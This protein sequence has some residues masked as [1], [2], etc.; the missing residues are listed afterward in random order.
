MITKKIKCV[1]EIKL[2]YLQKN[3]GQMDCMIKKEMVECTEIH[4][5][6]CIFCTDNYK[7]MIEGEEL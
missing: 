4:C 3:V 2:P 1:K 5:R 7:T 6:E